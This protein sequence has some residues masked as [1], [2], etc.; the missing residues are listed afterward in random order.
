[1]VST[2]KRR[3]P[4][5][6]CTRPAVDRPGDPA[7]AIRHGR[8]MVNR[9]SR[10][11]G[12]LRRRGATLVLS[13]LLIVAMLGVVAFAVDV[14]YVMLVRTQLQVAAD[15]AAMAAAAHLG[16][17]FEEILGSAHEY[18]G[19]HFAGGKP[20]DVEASDVELGFWD[21]AT[22]VFT[23]SDEM[24]NAVRVTARRDASAG[25]EA[26]LFF[27]RLFGNHSFRMSASAVA[28]ANPRDIA[29]VID[30]SGSMNND[31]EPCWATGAIN[32]TFADEGYPTIGD[33]LMQDVYDDF[34]F[35]S[36]P[37]ATQ[38]VGEAAGV[39]RNR[40]AYAELTENRG[41]LTGRSVPS[42]Y[43]IGTR[44]GE[45]T[46]KQKGYSWIIDT[47][48]A[49][50]MP[51]ALPAPVSSRNYDYWEKYLDYIMY[52]VYVRSRGW[53][54]YRQDGDRIDDFGNPSSSTFP[55]VSRSVPRSYRNQIGYRTYVQFMMDHGRDR[56]PDGRSYVPLSRHSA[57]CPWHTETTAGGTLRFPPREQPVHAARRATIAALEVVKER[58]AGISDP[59]QRDW[60]SIVAFDS[61]VGGGPVLEQTLTA[62]YDRAMRAC[63]RLQAVADDCASTATEAGTLMAKEH[64]RPRSEGGLGRSATNKVVVLLTDGV[65]NLYVSSR[66]EIDRFIRENP[67]DDFYG[68]WKYAYDASLMQAAVMEQ[69]N[70]YMFPVGIGLGTDYDF[71]DRLARMGATANDDGES[72]R[73]S[74]NPAEY[75]Q[76]L[77]SIFEEIITNPQV[78]LVQ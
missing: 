16:R 7:K 72:P 68:G 41:P 66:R 6:I 43:R 69:K 62:D 25:G 55:D 76:R 38:Y 12:C 42:Q 26:P 2:A 77:S 19:Y 32:D 10:E 45:G 18:A 54:P 63:T 28:M 53:L 60:V 5:P 27:A 52:P 21:S 1:M 13:A 50:V 61:L 4:P 71:M 35:G 11:R 51:N 74:G 33:D 48:I 20:V 8:L 78:R 3:L 34:G 36:F 14:G 39:A 57:D 58:N 67:S 49:Q 22:R 75:E 23:P 17:P 31:T 44:D 37:G 59:N 9:R 24:G 65:P 15:S 56:K 70:W 73:G 47:Q 29:F 40:Y 64:I 46:R 30:L